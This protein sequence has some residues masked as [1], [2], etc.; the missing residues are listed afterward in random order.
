MQYN[1]NTKQ[2]NA[3]NKIQA[4]TYR[5]IQ[6]YKAIKSNSIQPDTEH[7]NNYRQ[8]CTLVCMHASG[9]L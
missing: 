4:I 6:Q 5:R 1:K 2:L 8:I 7:L 9:Y 3:I